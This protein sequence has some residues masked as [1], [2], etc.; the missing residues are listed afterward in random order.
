MLAGTSTLALSATVV[1]GSPRRSPD[2]DCISTTLRFA[3]AGAV[4]VTPRSPTSGTADSS[5]P[6]YGAGGASTSLRQP[7]SITRGAS[8]TSA[9][10]AA[11]A[12]SAQVRARGTSAAG[13]SALGSSAASLPAVLA[14]SASTSA[15]DGAPGRLGAATSSTDDSRSDA[16]G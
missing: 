7:F 10:I 6:S 16:I 8:P 15:G 1:P 13:T 3:Y 5:A 12:A 11:S 9:M 4:S 14:T 2:D